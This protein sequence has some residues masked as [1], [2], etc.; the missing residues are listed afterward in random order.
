MIGENERRPRQSM[1]KKE[2]NVVNDVNE[3]RMERWE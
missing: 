2:V 1:E 3:G